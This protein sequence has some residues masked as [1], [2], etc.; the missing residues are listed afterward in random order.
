MTGSDTKAHILDHAAALFNQRGFAGTS[1]T[2]LMQATGLQKGGIYNHFNSKE[3][4]AIAAFTHAVKAIQARF[5]VALRRKQTAPD[6]LLALVEVYATMLDDPPVP[7]GCPLLNTAIDSDDQYPGLR[8]QTQEAM[9]AW[10]QLLIDIVQ[11]GIAKGELRTDAEPNSIATVVIATI[12]GGLM[13][14]KLYGQP[15]Y[16]HTALAHLTHYVMQLR[17]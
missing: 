7:G 9:N 6:R 12:E 15:S 10:R 14:S 1:M 2:D 8:K 11:R 17:P 3:E 4:L 5:R 13:L 16:L